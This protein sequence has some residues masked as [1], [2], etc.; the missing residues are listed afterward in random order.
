M[1]VYLCTGGRVHALH[2]Q[3]AAAGQQRA[4]GVHHAGVRGARVRGRHAAAH[5]ARAR[6][7]L[8]RLRVR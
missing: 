8:P 1:N 2:V 7:L 6:R 4:R 3:Q 5:H